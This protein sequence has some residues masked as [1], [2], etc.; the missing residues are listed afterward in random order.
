MSDLIAV[1][2][3]D[4]IVALDRLKRYRRGE[5]M[6]TVWEPLEHYPPAEQ[7]EDDRRVLCNA[8]I[9]VLHKMETNHA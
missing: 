1:L 7:R 2:P 6:S 3:V 4:A 8:I 5:V 9:D